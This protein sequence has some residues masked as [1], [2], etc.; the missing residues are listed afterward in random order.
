MKTAAK[1][2]VARLLLQA[3]IVPSWPQIIDLDGIKVD[4]AGANLPT[5]VRRALLMGIYEAPERHFVSQWLEK[6]DH[7]LELG[8]SIGIVS[9]AIGKAIGKEGKLIC[10]EANNALTR[11]FRH[12][13]ALNHISAELV[14]CLACPIW[15]NQIPVSIYQKTFVSSPNSLVGR[16]E[17]SSSGEG[18]VF[19]QTAAEL[20]AS[21]SLKPSALVVDIE[22]AEEVWAECAPCFPP[23]IRTIII[24]LH[25]G[26]VGGRKI[27]KCVSAVFAEGFELVDLL[28][29]VVVFRRP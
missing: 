17:V 23:T 19:W 6:G 9:S 24:E 21:N 25:P 26:I 2:A 27:A 29:D 8:A 14:N 15:A 1:L 10:V 22:G 20:C 3:H 16:A 18:S 13:L 28:G 12:Q 7:V 5:W 4:L 11:A